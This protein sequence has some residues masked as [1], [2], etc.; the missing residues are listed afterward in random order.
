MNH[1]TVVNSNRIIKKNYA[2]TLYISEVTSLTE[3]SLVG[4]LYVS[5]SYEWNA[6]TRARNISMAGA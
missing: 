6:E 3:T 5:Q 1:V 4:K 2:G